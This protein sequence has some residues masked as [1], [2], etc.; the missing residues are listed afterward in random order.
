MAVADALGVGLG[1]AGQV[2]VGGPPVLRVGWAVGGNID[3]E[4]VEAVRG[5]LG[6]RL[7]G[8]EGGGGAVAVRVSQ[9]VEGGD[10]NGVRGGASNPRTGASP[11][12]MRGGVGRVGKRM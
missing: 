7:Q 10:V 11:H 6:L 3:V 9:V 8:G 12:P 4:D 2:G 1:D 5:L